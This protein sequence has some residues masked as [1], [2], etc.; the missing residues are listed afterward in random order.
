MPF[1]QRRKQLLDIAR[2]IVLESGVGRLTMA[3][4]AEGSGV[5]RSVVYDHFNN[6]EAVAIALLCDHYQRATAFTVERIRDP[7]TIFDYFDIL[8]D[9][10]FDLHRRGMPLSRTITSGFPRNSDVTAFHAEHHKLVLDVYQELLQQQGISEARSRLAAHVLADMIDTAAIGFAANN[11]ATD[12]E[13]LKMMV[14]GAI[15]NL[16]RGGGVKPSVPVESLNKMSAAVS[17]RM[18]I[19]SVATLGRSRGR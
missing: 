3:A 9:T 6:V 17:F 13:A 7:D 19:S 18:P 12:R 10:M 1:T 8:I 14:Q 15:S 5:S 11:K 16:V 4:I 2:T